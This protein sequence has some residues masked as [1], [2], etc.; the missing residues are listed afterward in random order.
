MFST[1]HRRSLSPV[2]WLGQDLRNAP[3]SAG[4]PRC[5]DLHALHHVLLLFLA[6]LA[7]TFLTFV[8]L[9][10]TVLFFAA[11]FTFFLVAF[12]AVSPVFFLFFGRTGSSFGCCAAAAVQL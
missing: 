3:R 8:F 7:G 10:F 1:P 11:F 6:F 9:R 12:R 4:V 2:I 5:C